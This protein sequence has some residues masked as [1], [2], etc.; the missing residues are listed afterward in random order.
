[1]NTGRYGGLDLGTNAGWC[2]INWTPLAHLRPVDTLRGASVMPSLLASGAYSLRRALELT[3]EAGRWDGYRSLLNEH[4]GDCDV[5][6]YERVPPA[7]HTGG[8][9]AHVYG[10]LLATLQLWAHDTGVR[11]Q[12]IT[13]QAAKRALTGSS[14]AK[15]E[16]MVRSAKRLLDLVHVT[17]DQA[18]AIGVAL[19][20]V[21]GMYRKE[22]EWQKSS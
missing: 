4:M 13:I 2:V 20:G 9:A 7:A 3:G 10:G 11:L 22:Y 12:P 18:D 8:R 5:I 14:S 19:A 6:F 17:E 16:A 1:M 21:R 15:K